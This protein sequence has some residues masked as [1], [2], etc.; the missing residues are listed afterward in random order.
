MKHQESIASG[1]VNRTV[2]F[3]GSGARIGGNYIKHYVKKTFNSEL[4]EE[5]LHR[6]N[7]DELYTT[8][9]E[10]KGSALKV[11]Q[12]LSMDQGVL[13]AAYSNK[14]Q[15]AQYQAPPL[16]GPL[17]IKSFKSSVGKSPLEVFDS[18][19][20]NA[21]HAASIGQVHEA[22][23]NGKKLAVKIQYPGVAESI[24]SDLR[25]V[26]PIAMRMFNLSE[27]ELK[28]YMAEVEEKLVE[29]TDYE[30]ELQR[31]MDISEKCASL[32][33][34]RFARYYPE[35]SSSKVLTM[36]WLDGKHLD[37]FLA[38][39]PSLEIRNKIGQNLWDFYQFQIHELKAVHADPHPGNFIFHDDGTLGIIDFGCIKEIP[40]DFYLDF[41][42][43]IN[44][45]NLKNRE[46]FLFHLSNIE[47]IQADDSE[48][49]IALVMEVFGKLVELLSRPMNQP[50]FDF[51][52]IQYMDAIYRLGD[53]LSKDARIRK[54]G[55]GRG[56]KHMLYLNRTFFG[57]YSML[58]KLGAQIQ[59]QE[60]ASVGAAER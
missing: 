48:E 37:D 29:E 42:S 39:N 41:F 11:A 30:L 22:Q 33:G 31:S 32:S 54:V 3:L 4:G 27:R 13:P 17:A 26:K 53:S 43:L 58:H 24:R 9:S 52:D 2:K 46:I 14:F 45:E 47:M 60:Y 8:L 36:D 56:S 16:S 28:K 57:L 7:A 59:N 50:E 55:G 6:E 12:M 38:S 34:L 44:P 19:S 21:T 1:K 35:F 49:T 40:E 51:G 10:L 15:M 25:L 18:F 5:E 20:L 23:V